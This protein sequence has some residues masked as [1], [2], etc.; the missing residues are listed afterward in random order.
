MRKKARNLGAATMSD[1]P[2]LLAN[3]QNP[4]GG[5][6]GIDGVGGGKDDKRELYCE[7][8]CTCEVEYY[9]TSI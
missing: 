5:I 3:C 8:I 6:V 7:K 9:C 4:G 1:L 2:T